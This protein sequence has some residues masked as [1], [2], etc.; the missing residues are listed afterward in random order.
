ML[1]VV[2]L[3]LVTGVAPA[4]TIRWSMANEYPATPI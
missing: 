1:A 4:Q 3:L 2:I